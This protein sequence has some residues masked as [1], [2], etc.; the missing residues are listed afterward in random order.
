[1]RKFL[2]FVLVSLM[3]VGAIGT[4]AAQDENEGLGLTVYIDG[5]TFGNVVA[6][7]Y[8]FAG[9]DGQ[10]G[11]NPGIEFAKTFGAIGFST[12]LEFDLSFADPLEAD[13]N[14]RIGGDYALDLS[15]TSTL[16]FSLWNKLHFTGGDDGTGDGKFA[17]ADLDQIQDEIVP[18]IRFDQKLG[19]GIIYG[20]FELTFVI[21][22][23]EGVDLDILTGG[24]VLP[25]GDEGFQIGV[26]T[27]MGV[28]GYIQPELYFST[29]DADDDVFKYFNIC[30]GYKTGPIDAYATFFIP[31]FKDGMKFEGL[32]I[33]PGVSY[34]IMSGL[35]AYLELEFSGLGGDEDYGC[36][37]GFTPTIGVS[38]S[39]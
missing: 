39:F 9:E 32:A 7:E 33:T 4:L 10:A 1:M 13:L 30:A 17:D 31:T 16:T 38:Y 6:D 35:S 23:A 14:W 3:A 5:F 26:E 11:I 2:V 34:E 36:E 22:T 20:I 12:A 29:N 21:H 24:G 15:D 8:T 28:Y 25:Y 19:F 18:A 27:D 37:F